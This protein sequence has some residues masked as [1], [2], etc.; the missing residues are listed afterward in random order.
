MGK[1]RK[2]NPNI[3]N[4]KKDFLTLKN[5]GRLAKYKWL[6]F[7]Y[8]LNENSNIC[9]LAYV[10]SKKNIPRAVD[11]NRLKR[12][13]RDQALN[14]SIKGGD[15]LAVFSFKGKDFYKNLKRKDFNDVFTK[16]VNKIYAF[17]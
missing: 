15:F 1:S 14:T 6:K 9:R 12:W 13:L 5:K 17:F 2:S 4:Q 8:I 11:R 7:V 10:V 3:L 16:T